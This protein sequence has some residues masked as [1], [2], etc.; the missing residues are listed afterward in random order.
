MTGLVVAADADADFN[1]IVTYL[2]REAGA[3]IA[4]HYSRRFN[5]TLERLLKFPQSG[6][7]RPMLGQDVGRAHALRRTLQRQNSPRSRCRWPVACS[8]SWLR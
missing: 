8:V 2:R 6:A 7:P 4:A 3:R 5:L 1:D